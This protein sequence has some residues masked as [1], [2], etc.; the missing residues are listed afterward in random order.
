MQPELV[1]RDMTLRSVNRELRSVEFVASTDAIDS[2]D[3]IVEQDWDL[4]RFRANPVILFGHNSRELPIGRAARCEVVERD[5]K[6]QLECTIQFLSAQANPMAENVWHSVQE[7]GLRAVSVGFVP[8]KTQFEKRNGREV[9]VLSK[10]MLH[11]I[12][13]VPI[14]ANPEA[15][16]R[17]KAKARE[18]A[19]AGSQSQI[20]RETNMDLNERIAKLDAEKSVVEKQLVDLQK[21]MVT[22]KAGLAAAEG[23][24]KVLQEDRDHHKA[25]AEKAEKAMVEAEVEALVGKRITPAEKED[26]VYLALHDRPRFERMVAA[27]PVMT[28][29]GGSVLPPEDS[30]ASSSVLASNGNGDLLSARIFGS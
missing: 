25:R 16:A 28:V 10:N 17:M 24:I 12:S 2:Y 1:T 6:K 29:L 15:V 4:E 22:V 14:P 11:E 9:F 5:G 23:T 13:V 18:A 30:A 7:G 8:G 3:E 27:R 20:T 26:Y 19:A 21:E